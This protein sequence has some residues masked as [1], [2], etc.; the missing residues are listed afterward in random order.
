MNKKSEI[1]CPKC[2]SSLKDDLNK[3][4]LYCRVCSKGFPKLSIND[5][6]IIDFISDDEDFTAGFYVAE[7]QKI[8][9]QLLK[10]FD[11]T[12]FYGLTKAYETLSSNQNIDFNDGIN[13][14]L[15]KINPYDLNHGKDSLLKAE[16]MCN[17]ISKKIN[18]DGVAL[19][20]GCG[21]GYFTFEFA[22]RFKHLFVT[23][24]SLCFLLLAI[25]FISQRQ[26][27]LSFVGINKKI[28][29]LRCNIEELPIQKNSIHFIHSNQ[30]IEHVNNQDKF[31]NEMNRVSSNN[32]GLTYVVSP[33]KFSALEEPH[34][35]L[36][37]FGLYPKIIADHLI[38][39]QN[40]TIDDVRPISYAA[41]HSMFSISFNSNFIIKGVF[42]QL[43]VANPSKLKLL[44]SLLTKNIL[45]NYI[46]NNI[47][48]IV[49]PCHYI[50]AWKDEDN[51]K[52]I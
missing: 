27:E 22:Q 52:G 40:R 46:F 49:L 25:K 9:E 45:I 38:R 26:E 29:L 12:D 48:I 13:Q 47:L 10:H 31:L 4:S 2:H 32:S 34:Y 3:Q 17:D 41:A 44:V 24:C 14:R 5:F 43:N 19:E 20:N 1:T 8:F 33:N 7:D 35:R 6:K 21:Y 11:K 30:V 39:Y 15:K 50:L 18:Y 37:F 36:R 23:D 28:T 16:S 42:P 51:L